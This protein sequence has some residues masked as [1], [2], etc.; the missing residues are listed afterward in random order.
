MDDLKLVHVF[1]PGKQDFW[2]V[3]AK[4]SKLVKK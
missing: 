4:E 2:D 1:H 3:V